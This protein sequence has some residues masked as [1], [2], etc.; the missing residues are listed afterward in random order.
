MIRYQDEQK[1]AGKWRETSGFSVR[2]ELES[3]KH[4]LGGTPRL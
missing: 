1:C 3:Q 2:Q 4:F